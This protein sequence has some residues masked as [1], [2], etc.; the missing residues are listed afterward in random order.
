MATNM[1][2][3]VDNFD[4][5]D[6]EA[7]GDMAGTDDVDDDVDNDVAADVTYGFLGYIA[8]LLMGPI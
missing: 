6:A 5:M 3:D 4:D 7:G 2:I 1:A 8:H